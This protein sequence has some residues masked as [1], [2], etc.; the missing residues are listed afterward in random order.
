[1]M[2]FNNAYENPQFARA[3]SQLQFPGTYYLAYRDLSAIIHTYVRGKNALDFGCGAGRSTQFLQKLGFETIGVDISENMLSIAA[4]NESKGRY[5]LI[6]DGNFRQFSPRSFN[7]ILSAFTFDNIPTWT[8][9][10]KIL[11]DLAVLLQDHGV[12][13]NLVSNPEIYVNEWASFSTKDFPGNRK[14]KTGDIVKIINTAIADARPVKDILWTEKDY[15]R[16][17]AQTGLRVI[18][19]HKPLAD[20]TEPYLWKNETR[21]P[22]WCIY[23]LKKGKLETV[24]KED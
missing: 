22:P 1:M 5:Y 24:Q 3:Y 15:H 19:M 12:F 21:L 4:A 20:G 9:K 10:R 14:A 13:I 17:Y 7:L 2:K 16:V 23:I 6:E 18:T 11:T 8:K